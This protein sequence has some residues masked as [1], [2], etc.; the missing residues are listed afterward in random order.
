MVGILDEEKNRVISREYTKN[1]VKMLDLDFYVEISAETGQKI[2]K[3]FE[4][5]TKNALEKLSISITGEKSVSKSPCTK[6]IENDISKTCA[7][8]KNQHK[9]TL[10]IYFYELI[11]K[12]K[13]KL[14]FEEK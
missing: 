12:I 9:K 5:L 1:M 2:E 4:I 8:N 14:S 13:R 7:K 6:C 11:K 3:I 10:K